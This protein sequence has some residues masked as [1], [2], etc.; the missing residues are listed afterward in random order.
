ME[1]LLFLF[2]LLLAAG[3][4]FLAADR[5]KL[6]TLAADGAGLDGA[7]LS[8]GRDREETERLSAIVAALAD[9]AATIHADAHC[10]DLHALIGDVC[11][12]PRVRV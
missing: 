12:P 5:L 2:G 11:T 4:F 10:T 6:P 9:P 8:S 3:L 7:V 1:L